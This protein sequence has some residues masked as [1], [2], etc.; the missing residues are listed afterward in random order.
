MDMESGYSLTVP[1]LL[2]PSAAQGDVLVP[3]RT[4]SPK[5]DIA[6]FFEMLTAAMI[7][8]SHSI[9][10]SPKSYTGSSFSVTDLASAILPI[11][12][13]VDITQ[14]LRSLN[15]LLPHTPSH[16]AISGNGMYSSPAKYFWYC[17]NCGLASSLSI[18]F[19]V[20]FC[21]GCGHAC[22]EGCDVGQCSVPLNLK[23]GK[24]S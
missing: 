23:R 12:I 8:A 16:Q 11:N 15:A 19:G 22:C 3:A 18:G 10:V 17:C 13:E 5:I 6:M 14:V 9:D 24:G 7:E 2:M 4:D 1:T 20:V 21:N